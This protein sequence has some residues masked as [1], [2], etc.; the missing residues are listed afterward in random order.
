MIIACIYDWVRFVLSPDLRKAVIFLRSD[1]RNTPPLS[2]A[3]AAARSG[4]YTATVVL[5]LYKLE[6]GSQSRWPGGA[7]CSVS[8]RCVSVL[9]DTRVEWAATSSVTA[10]AASSPPSMSMPCLV[11]LPARLPAPQ[12]PCTCLLAV[13]DAM[14]TIGLHR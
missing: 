1:L 6:S 14:S 8:W 9:S 10:S 11:S 13:V 7:L 5:A 12:L 3:T 2:A 4:I